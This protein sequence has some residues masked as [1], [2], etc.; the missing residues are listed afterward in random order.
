MRDGQ[1]TSTTKA[2][3]GPHAFGLPEKPGIDFMS[4]E[5]WV[6]VGERA[7]LTTREL[8]VAILIFEGETRSAI[9]RRLGCAPGTVRVYIDRLFAK[10]N[11]QDRVDLVLRIVRIH[12]AIEAEQDA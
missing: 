1:A 5:A 10:L 11:V 7:N 4:G 12:R 9:A 6:Q 8:T 3:P 2:L